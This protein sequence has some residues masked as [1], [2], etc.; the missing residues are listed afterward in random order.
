MLC[1]S[2]SLAP[3]LSALSFI[4]PL[5]ARELQ[6]R[7]M[8]DGGGTMAGGAPPEFDFPLGRSHRPPA[9]RR[10]AAPGISPDDCLPSLRPPPHAKMPQ[11]EFQGSLLSPS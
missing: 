3:I 4:S 11:P 9:P 6:R 5:L 10:L 1:A 2:R 8:Y 7:M